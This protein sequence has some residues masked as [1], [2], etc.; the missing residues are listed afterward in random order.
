MK[1]Y[2]HRMVQRGEVLSYEGNIG[3]HGHLQ[4]AVP[5]RNICHVWWDRS[6]ELLFK[7]RFMDCI[8]S[9]FCWG[10]KEG[11]IYNQHSNFGEAWIGGLDGIYH[12]RW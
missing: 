6:G 4:H 10:M 5:F 7:E 3:V 11:S 9:E 1:L 12:M 8:P 2:D